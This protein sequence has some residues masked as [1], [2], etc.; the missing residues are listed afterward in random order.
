M[1]MYAW[2]S[3]L[4]AC[5]FLGLALLI[6]SV[7]VNLVA[8]SVMD[9]EDDGEVSPFGSQLMGYDIQAALCIP[10]CIQ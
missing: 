5:K 10:L 9:P 2:C 6:V 8:E 4:V 7:S 3:H 1:I